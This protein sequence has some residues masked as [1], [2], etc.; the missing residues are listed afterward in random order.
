MDKK[1]NLG[2]VT[3]AVALMVSV[4]AL[5]VAYATYSS[6]VTIEG[7]GT[8]A[9]AKW[10]VKFQNLVGASNT[11]TTPTGTLGNSGGFAVTARETSRPTLSSSGTSITN[12]GVEVKTP[13]DYVYYV[14]DIV[15]DG[16]FAAE[17]DTGFAVP[18]PT[19]TA[20]ASSTNDDD[21]DN[22][23]G[24]LS[25]TL[26]YYTPSTQTVGS[27]VATGNTWAIGE[28]KTVILKLQYNTTNNQNLLPTDD[29]SIGNLDITIPFIQSTAS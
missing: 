26:N 25:Y 10:S 9:A 5:T 27:A 3:G 13:G 2:V 24:L 28:S 16:D 11:G 20:G 19:C 8:A 1:K 21:D 12:M 4:I 29:V 14:F 18:T 22:V 23:C 15:N 17:I 7:S 6:N